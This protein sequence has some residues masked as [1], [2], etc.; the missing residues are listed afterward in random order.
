MAT[1]LNNYYASVLTNE[2]RASP[3]PPEVKGTEKILNGMLIVKSYILRTTEKIGVS[4]APDQR[5]I[6][7]I[8]LKGI[9]HQKCKKL[10]HIQ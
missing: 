7:L 8:T 4:K 1:I 10:C 9:E 6:N 3:Q 5:K 2:H